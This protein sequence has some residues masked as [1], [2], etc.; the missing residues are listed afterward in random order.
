MSPDLKHAHYMS[1]ALGLAIRGQGQCAPNPAVGAIIV[2]NGTII[3][4]GWHRGPGLPHAEVEAIKQANCSL[5]GASIYI[6]LEPCC[7]YGRT[8]P[9]TESIIAH[10]ITHVYYGLEDP[11]P[12]VSGRGIQQLQ[13]AQVV[14][15][16]VPTASYQNILSIL[17]SKPPKPTSLFSCQA[18][19]HPGWRLCCQSGTPAKISGTACKQLTFAGRNK[20]DIILTTARTFMLDQPLLN[21]RSGQTASSK[22]LI[23]LDRAL[24]TS[25]HKNFMMIANCLFYMILAKL[26][27]YV[28]HTKVIKTFII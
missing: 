28:H 23:I 25:N 20:A 12:T 15:T 14:Y 26:V 7:H 10:G 21:I 13:Q 4:C 5:V 6:T 17:Y 22:P 1:L 9:C 27:H 24:K 8:P 19:R 18:G 11:N 16:L 3:G 2:K